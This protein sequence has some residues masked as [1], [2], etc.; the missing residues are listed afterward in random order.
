VACGQFVSHRIRW[1]IVGDPHG[2]E[3]IHTVFEPITARCFIPSAPGSAE[4]FRSNQARQGKYSA[5]A[6]IVG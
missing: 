5:N 2:Q 3:R 4:V 6:V 1:Y